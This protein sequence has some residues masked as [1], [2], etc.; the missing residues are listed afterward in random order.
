MSISI[1]T[2]ICL[3]GGL[4]CPNRDIYDEQKEETHLRM[5]NPREFD[6]I[7]L[8]FSATFTYANKTLKE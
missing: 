3:Q 8:V 4:R 2:L 1:Y 7:I 5:E 6:L